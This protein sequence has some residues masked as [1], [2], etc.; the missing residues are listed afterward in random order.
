MTDIDQT[1]GQGKVCSKCGEWK[2]L[3]EYHKDKTAKDGK[4]SSCGDCVKVKNAKWRAEN[5]DKSKAAAENYRANNPE[6]SRESAKRTRDKRGSEITAE[7][8]KKWKEENPEYFIEYRSANKEKRRE[9]NK[10]WH[11]A[12]PEKSKAKQ[13][14]NHQNNRTSPGARLAV[15]IKSSMWKVLKKGAKRGRRTFDLLG[16]SINDLRSHLESL[17]GDG[18]TWENYGD[19]H[20]D[21]KIP[22]AAF[23]F[24]TPED[25]DFKRCWALSNLQPLWATENLSKSDKLFAPFQPSLL[26]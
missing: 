25:T 8:N 11:R 13:K 5:P 2:P 14:R 26:L 3:S 7:Y 20:V 12:N 24:E 10:E 15:N 19:W 9:Y 16:Y 6:K 21:H 4:R 18:M 22:I 23:N 17:F 1:D